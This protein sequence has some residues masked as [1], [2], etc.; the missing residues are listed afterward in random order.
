ERMCNLSELVEKRGEERGLKVGEERGLKLG[1]E[2]GKLEK[3]RTMAISMLRDG[4]AREQVAKYA[5]VSVETLKQW[6]LEAL[7]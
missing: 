7:H 4:M 3:A 2:R 6:E 1:E 5:G